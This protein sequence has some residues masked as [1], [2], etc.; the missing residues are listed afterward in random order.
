MPPTG[1]KTGKEQAIDPLE[2]LRLKE[3]VKE[4]MEQGFF[5]AM[6]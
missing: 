6:G 4:D 1:L 3:G 5:K 2:G